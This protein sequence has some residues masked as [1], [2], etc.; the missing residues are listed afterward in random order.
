M[1][2]IDSLSIA[3]SITVMH[4]Y[5]WQ[6]FQSFVSRKLLEDKLLDQRERM[7]RK[8]SCKIGCTNLTYTNN[9]Y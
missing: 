3:I 1:K 4:I 9:E 5:L 8:I 6:L 7:S 2:A